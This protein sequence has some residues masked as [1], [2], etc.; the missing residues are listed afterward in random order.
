[1]SDK[2]KILVVDDT[3]FYRKILKDTLAHFPEAEI[4]GTASNGRIALNKIDQLKPDLITLDLE[5]PTLNGLDTL[6]ELKK[7]ENPPSALMVSAH[8][9]KDAQVTMEALNLGAFDFIA[10]PSGGDIRTNVEIL[11]EQFK[12]VLTAYGIRQKFK[13]NLTNG[14]APTKTKQTASKTPIEIPVSTKKIKSYDPDIIAIGISTGGPKA[15]ADVVPTLNSKIKAPIVIVQHMPPLFTKALA[16]S[17]NAKTDLE[18]VEAKDGDILQPGKIYIAPG[19]SQMKVYR[20]GI[21]SRGKIEITDDPPENFCKPAVDY[22]FRS[23]ADNYEK[24]ALGIIM[25]GMGRDGVI[26]AKM[27][28][29]KGAKIM[30]QNKETC[31]VF[32]MPSE[33][34]R[35]GVVDYVL[36]LNQIAPEINRISIGY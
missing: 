5:M 33:A 25:T 20:K 27:M 10:K 19:G 7:V 13:I 17:L 11:K 14:K 28:R 22:L 34:I 6:R 4:V 31:V 15:L 12:P 29:D 1:M 3:I 26:G 21:A 8:T 36:P 2:I 9:T 32:G 35:K 24:N 18:V 30:A 23:V 16:S